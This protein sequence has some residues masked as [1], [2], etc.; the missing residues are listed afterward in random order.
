MVSTL[1][2]MPASST[3]WM[4]SGMPASARR[5]GRL[6]HF[7]GQLARVREVDAHPERMML[8]SGSSSALV[9]RIGQHRRHLGAEADELD[10]LD[11]AQAAEQVVELLVGDR[12]RVA[13]PKSARRGS[14]YGPR[15]TA[16]ALSHW[17]CGERVLAARLRRP[18]ASA[19]SSGSRSSRSRST[20]TERGPGSGGQGP[21]R[22]RRDPRR[23]GR[24]PRRGCEV[25]RTD[26]NMRTSQAFARVVAGSAG[27]H[28]RA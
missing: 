25:L 17:D 9:T 6:G 13:R 4:P 27:W 11:R 15:C 3:V 2:L 5:A 26:R 22:P 28:S 20:G 19:C 10:V 16:S 8:S 18:C 7:R 24:Q 12:Q 21:A 23:A 1:S 14:R